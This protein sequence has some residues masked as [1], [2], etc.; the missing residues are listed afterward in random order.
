MWGSSGFALRRRL[1]AN[2]RDVS[3]GF[4]GA[5]V[6]RN[7]ADNAFAS[8]NLPGIQRRASRYLTAAL[9]EPPQVRLR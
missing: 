8:G 3:L 2:N 7:D 9:V 6:D 5:S 4:T 1:K